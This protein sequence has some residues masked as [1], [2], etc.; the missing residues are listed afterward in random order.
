MRQVARIATGVLLV[1]L[2]HGR[3]AAGRELVHQ[4]FDAPGD[5]RAGAVL[6]PE[7]LEIRGDGKQ[8]TRFAGPGPYKRALA[9]G[10]SA[11]LVQR[12]RVPELPQV[13]GLDPAGWYAVAAVDV[14]GTGAATGATLTLASTA[15]GRGRPAAKASMGVDWKAPAR[16][17]RGSPVVRRLWA[18][19]PGR[20]LRQQVKREFVLELS[21]EGRSPVVVDDLRLELYHE[22]PSRKLLGKPNGKNGPD[23]LAAGALGFVAL[24]EH[25]AT[26]FSLLA[27]TEDGPAHA[28]GLR[29]GDL[30]IA[31]EGG[32]LPSG[33]LA[34]GRAWF[35][36][37]HEAVLGR[38]LLA[39]LEGGHKTLRVTRLTAQGP[40]E[41]TLRIGHLLAPTVQF[42][43]GRAAEQLRNDVVAW[44]ASRQKPDG[45]WPGQRVVNSCLA[46]LC[47]LGTRDRAHRPALRRLV[48]ALL[49]LHPRA[50]DATGFSFWPIAWQG[51]FFAE[52]YL[53][54]HDKRVLAW[55]REAI[56]WLPS[57]THPSTW[58]I[59]AFGHSP[60][61]LPYGDKALMA[62]CSH[63]LVFEALAERCGIDGGIWDHVAPYVRRSWSD[64]DEGG[65][66]GMGYNPAHKDKQ[67]FWSR[68]GLTALALHLR[69]KEPRMRKA[70]ADFMVERHPW[71]LNSHAYG[72]PGG[73]LGLMGAGRDGTEGLHGDPR[74]VALALSAR[75]GAG[76]RT[77]VFDATHGG[78][79]HGR[80][81]DLESGL[82]GRVL[83]AQGR[84]G[85]DG[86][87]GAAVDALGET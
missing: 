25:H 64:P 46:G 42:P 49:E 22:R 81:R 56:D 43:A 52:Y 20:V 31:V 38:T 45:F 77:A 82:R 16:G 67:E 59:P 10:R 65:H 37:S 26:A 27:V 18:R 53:A 48:K 8:V 11:R 75:L 40:E 24:V 80:G 87:Q 19:I 47:L 35:T 17:D 60:K 5:V 13:E 7:G 84:A 74:G 4:N 61:G 14:L 50:R 36:T 55:M 57:T 21:V 78:A 86:R 39:R 72:E 1:L 63:L 44:V 23:L 2:A 76:L 85:H 6:A 34:A 73:A 71:M 68:T 29:V 70:M 83:G 30:I 66:G 28:A 58:E 12:V 9:F 62:P 15:Q 51:I 3:S 32:P 69:G 79:L 33:S 41:R 54:S